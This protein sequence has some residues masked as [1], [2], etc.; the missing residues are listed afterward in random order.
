MRTLIISGGWDGHHP[1]AVAE[2]LA[3]HIGGE[4]TLSTSLDDCP[5][6]HEFDVVIPNWTMGEI[7]GEQ[8]QALLAAVAAG[9]GLVGL[10][11]G[12]GDAFRSCTE[13][14]FAVGGQFVAHPGDG[15]P[16]RVRFRGE[17]P[18]TAG[19]S[20]FDVVTEQYYMHVDPAIR[21]LATCRFDEFDTEM[22]AVW[23]KLHGEGRVFYCSLGH[24]PSVVAHPT[25]LEL[26]RRGVLWAASRGD[27]QGA[28]LGE[29][30]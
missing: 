23:T 3:A 26:M 21:V 15:R 18:L 8:A 20:D 27:L 2:L 13:F 9:T 6:A 28:R 22:P 5:Q 12:M 1:H 24:D 7:S 4:V 16:Y 10:H 19:L 14:Q 17:W 30:L 11:G 29:V 25:V